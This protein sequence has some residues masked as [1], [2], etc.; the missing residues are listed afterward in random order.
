MW[1]PIS[2][3]ILAAALLGSV[4]AG[5]GA[6]AATFDEDTSI[7]CA[8]TL[9]G[10]IIDGDLDRLRKAASRQNLLSEPDSG[11][12]SNASDRALCLDSPGGN[13][14]AGRLMAGLIHQF[15]ITTRVEA[16]ASCY[17]A[18][19]FM[20]MAG[21]SLG[22]EVDGASRYMHARA[23]VGSVEQGHWRIHQ[24]WLLH[25]GIRFAA[26]VLYVAFGGNPFVRSG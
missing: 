11:E 4:L 26:N 20:F 3:K 2:V 8:I 18:C 6:R 13:Y 10:E 5:A 21:R 22:G 16:G 23:N 12:E 9:K 24:I 7:G 19:A 14:V 1:K 25:F 15:G 17:S